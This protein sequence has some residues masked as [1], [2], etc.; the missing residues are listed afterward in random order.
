MSEK[1]TKKHLQSLIRYGMNKF[2][3]LTQLRQL[4]ST[5][6]SELGQIILTR[7][8]FPMILYWLKKRFDENTA[9]YYVFKNGKEKKIKEINGENI[10]MHTVWWS[11]QDFP[12][13]SDMRSQKFF[14]YCRYDLK[15]KKKTNYD[16]WKF[17]SAEIS[18][19]ANKI[20]LANILR[21]NPEIVA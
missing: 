8:L 20:G 18:H 19:N 17:L 14:G 1:P 4:L 6:A 12:Q 9:L 21:I 2:R 7:N 13:I 15:N 10:F 11:G 3:I 16:K 5:S